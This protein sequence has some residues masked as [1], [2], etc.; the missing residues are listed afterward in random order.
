MIYNHITDNSIMVLIHPD[1]HKC[2]EY[3]NFFDYKKMIEFLK[4]WEKSALRPFDHK[5]IKMHNYY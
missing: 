2:I 5:S 4:K 1:H 3:D